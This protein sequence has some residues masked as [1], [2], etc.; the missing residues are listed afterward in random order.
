[1]KIYP[2]K[3]WKD[4]MKRPVFKIPVEGLN[5]LP[6]DIEETLLVEY[7]ENSIEIYNAKTLKK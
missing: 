5:D 2:V 1:M 4:R 7:K 3:I 6:I